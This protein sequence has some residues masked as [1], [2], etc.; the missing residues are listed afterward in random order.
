[1]TTSAGS[2]SGINP[3]TG[4]WTPA[5]PGQRPPFRSGHTYSVKTGVYSPRKVRP[6]AEKILAGLLADPQP[7]WIAHPLLRHLLDELAT[8]QARQKLLGAYFD[9]IS[10]DDCAGDRCQCAGAAAAMDL[11]RTRESTLLGRLGA[12]P[13]SPVTAPKKALWRKAA[14]ESGGREWW[15]AA[16]GVTGRSTWD[17]GGR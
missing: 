2:P 8:V 16:T 13:M 5:F 7:P 17:A 15:F 12:A 6:L 14:A 4:G 9:T 10:D 3:E 11:A 1:M